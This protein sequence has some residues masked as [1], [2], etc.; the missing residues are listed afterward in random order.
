MQNRNF[1]NL[2][3]A[4]KVFIWIVFGFVF[5]QGNLFSSKAGV[6]RSNHK[7]TAFNQ[8]IVS[9]HNRL[10]SDKHLS[11][12]ENWNEDKKVIARYKIVKIDQLV[13]DDRFNETRVDNLLQK[14]AYR[15]QTQNATISVS[16]SS[17]SVSP[18]GRATFTVSVANLPAGTTVVQIT[19]PS[20]MSGTFTP[21]IPSFPLYIDLTLQR[22]KHVGFLWSQMK[23]KSGI[24]SIR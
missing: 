9:S 11:Y 16:P 8:S 3:I 4:C 7:Q 24:T 19:L 22:L 2:L 13:N 17:Q 6:L 10:E 23:Q 1:N 21:V 12:E 15:V 14:A 20:T 18:G 5:L